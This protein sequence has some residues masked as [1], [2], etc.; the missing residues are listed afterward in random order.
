MGGC[1]TPYVVAMAWGGVGGR[2]GVGFR[3]A[4]R[5]LGGVLRGFP[6]KSGWCWTRS[7]GKYE[8]RRQSGNGTT[9]TAGHVGDPE[10]CGGIWSKNGRKS[11]ISPRSF[12]G[13]GEYTPAKF[14]HESEVD[15]QN[16][17]S[18]P[19]TTVTRCF[20]PKCGA[21]E[22]ELRT[23]TPKRRRGPTPRTPKPL[24]GFLCRK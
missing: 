18:L 20:P 4:C 19:Y 15:R 6:G 14:E 1:W 8:A 11:P 16:P 22:L 23:E 13:I 2:W 12:G 17:N 5:V 21:S 24:S 9:K 7:V 3:V 10:N